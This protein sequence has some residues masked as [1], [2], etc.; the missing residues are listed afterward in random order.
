MQ[1]FQFDD[2]PTLI[3]MMRRSL[4]ASP[5]TSAALNGIHQTQQRSSQQGPPPPPPPKAAAD[6]STPIDEDSDTD[7]LAALTRDARRS[8]TVR[9]MTSWLSGRIPVMKR[10]SLQQR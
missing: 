3:T 7:D 2:A 10:G 4:A 5:R 1:H 6:A 8:V 9:K